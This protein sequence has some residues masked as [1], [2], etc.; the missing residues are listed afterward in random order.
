MQICDSSFFS[1]LI[2]WVESRFVT[3]TQEKLRDVFTRPEFDEQRDAMHY[4][5]DE[6]ID[7]SSL[8]TLE[9]PDTV[10]FPDEGVTLTVSQT[11]PLLRTVEQGGAVVRL[12]NAPPATVVKFRA[13]SS[14]P[15]EDDGVP[16]AVCT[17]G[18]VY[19]HARYGPGEARLYVLAYARL[20]SDQDKEDPPG[21]NPAYP[22]FG[23]CADFPELRENFVKLIHQSPGIDAVAGSNLLD[24]LEAIEEVGREYDDYCEYM[25]VDPPDSGEDGGNEAPEQPLLF[26]DVAADFIAVSLIREIPGLEVPF[27]LQQEWLDLLDPCARVRALNAFVVEALD[28]LMTPDRIYTRALQAT[29]K[30]YERVLVSRGDDPRQ[31]QLRANGDKF[32]QQKLRDAR[33]QLTDPVA[34]LRG[35]LDT[36]GMPRAARAQLK[37]EIDRL[38]D[39]TETKTMEYLRC[40]ADLPWTGG[41]ADTVDLEGARRIL[42]ARH[43]GLREAKE[44]I[45][46][47]LAVRRR[48]RDARGTVLCFAGPS[49]VGK[50][51]LA[52]SIADA[53]GRRFADVS[54]NGMRHASDVR[55]DHRTWAGAQPGRI[56]R[57][58]QSLGARNPVF[59]LDELDTIGRLRA[60]RCSTRSTRRG[61]RR[62]T[63]T[64]STCRSTCR[65]CSSSPPR[66]CSAGFRRRCATAWRW[67]RSPAT[68]RPR[69]WRSPDGFSFRPGSWNTG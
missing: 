10:L 24:R 68:R 38:S 1:Q 26:L 67:S 61:T 54:C 69:S 53:L 28:D 57:K 11:D 6:P 55:G 62:F 34:R 36:C 2:C 50:S 35:K 58:L 37:P 16:G 39:R 12:G 32:L 43:F 18:T 13:R 47:H 30:R 48:K 65:R 41:K 9:L 27:R 66:T 64:T 5:G 40:L 49:G 19:V 60:W 3:P 46:E 31:E 29:I 59:V 45:L 21:R 20:I 25:L 15:R 56:I 7:V 33:A 63:T 23:F 17:L 51:S 22:V 4:L 14:Q 44:R 52:A 8:P 42:D